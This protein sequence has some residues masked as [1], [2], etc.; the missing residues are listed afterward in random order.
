MK[1]IYQILL[2]LEQTEGA[3]NV[4]D[5]CRRFILK[6]SYAGQMIEKRKSI[7]ARW[8]GEAYVRQKGICPRCREEK[9]LTEMTG[10]HIQPLVKGGKHR[11]GNI[12][13]LCKSCNSSKGANDLVMESKLTGRTIAEQF[14]GA[15]D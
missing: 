3:R 4:R 5:A 1:D 10:D 6:K 14:E 13:A 7:P 12:Q 2:D 15:S 11:K 9:L 8:L